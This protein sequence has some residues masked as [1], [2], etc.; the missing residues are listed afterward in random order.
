VTVVSGIRT[1]SAFWSVTRPTLRRILILRRQDS[2]VV[3]DPE[4]EGKIVYL[5]LPL[6]KRGNIQD[7]INAH[8]VSSTRFSEKE[9]L[10]LFKGTCE[11]VRAMHEY[12]PSARTAGPSAGGQE[13]LDHPDHADEDGASVP[14]V[15]AQRREEG[16]A[17]FDGDEEAHAGDGRAEGAIVPYAHRDLKP[18]FA[19]EVF[20]RRA[21]VLMSLRVLEM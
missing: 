1:S 11:A 12:R 6:Y 10:R 7:A 2:A 15:A 13:I 3:Q 20:R 16:E 5:F 4:G 19:S 14:L 18:G 8:S 9:M 21:I 17:I